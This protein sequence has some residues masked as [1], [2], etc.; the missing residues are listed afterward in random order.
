MHAHMHKETHTHA[1]THI[2][3]GGQGYSGCEG[4]DGESRDAEL[5]GWLDVSDASR[6]HRGWSLEHSVEDRLK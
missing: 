2:V 4:S 6:L 3:K 5:A 1:H